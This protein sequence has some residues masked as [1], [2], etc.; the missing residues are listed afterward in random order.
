MVLHVVSRFDV[1]GC[2]LGLMR[3]AQ[4][5]GLAWEAAL[6]DVGSWVWAPT[7]GLRPDLLRVWGSS[8]GCV[9]DWSLV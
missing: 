8:A 9:L 4:D 3:R 1:P 5:L 6:M 2:V 7:W